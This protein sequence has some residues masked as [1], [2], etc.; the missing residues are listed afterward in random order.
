MLQRTPEEYLFTNL[1]YIRTG[2]TIPSPIIFA[3]PHNGNRVPRQLYIDGLPLGLA[4]EFLATSH[5]AQDVNADKLFQTLWGKAPYIST[6]ENTLS[7]LVIDSDR[8][9]EAPNLIQ[10]TLLNGAIIPANQSL[11]EREKRFRNELY[12]NFHAA[13][14]DFIRASEEQF[15]RAHIFWIHTF[16]RKYGEDNRDDV[17]IGTFKPKTTEFT[18]VVESTLAKHSKG[19]FQFKPDA[20]YNLCLNGPNPERAKQ[21]A[22]QML[23]DNLGRDVIG[24]EICNDLLT[25][26]QGRDNVATVLMHMAYDVAE[27]YGQKDFLPPKQEAERYLNFQI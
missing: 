4:H 1:E 9:K 12:D 7:R 2:G 5:E 16:T 23:T 3:G 11:T 26:Q 13:K 8:A 19:R 14:K 6:I 25:T 15:G 17:D 21:N 27:R 20:P 10:N 24:I 22:G 18:D